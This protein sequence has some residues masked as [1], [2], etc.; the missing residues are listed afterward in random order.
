MRILKIEHKALLDAVATEYDLYNA[1]VKQIRLGSA[2]IALSN[3]HNTNT[4]QN[5]IADNKGFEVKPTKDDI[6]A[7][8]NK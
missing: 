7:L 6:E 4:I 1:A 5:V 8:N 3:M 2:V